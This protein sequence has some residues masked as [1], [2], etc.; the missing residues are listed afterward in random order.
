MAKFGIALGSGPRGRGFESRHSDQ[1]PQIL[2]QEAQKS[3]DFSFAWPG[4]LCDTPKPRTTEKA[5]HSTDYLAEM[6]TRRKRRQDRQRGCGSRFLIPI[7]QLFPC[8]LPPSPKRIPSLWLLCTIFWRYAERRL[9]HPSKDANLMPFPALLFP[10]SCCIIEMILIQR[11][12]NSE[13]EQ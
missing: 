10:M 12:C 2:V 4:N 9:I 7:Y 1:N 8:V 5:A 3:E 6:L 11:G 13:N